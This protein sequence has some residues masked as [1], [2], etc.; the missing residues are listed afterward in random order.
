[1]TQ[2]LTDIIC[3]NCNI[4][5]KCLEITQANPERIDV[6]F[7]YGGGLPVDPV[8]RER[9]RKAIDQIEVTNKKAF[10]KQLR[11]AVCASVFAKI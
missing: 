1:M 8:V 2:F 7:N 6:T 4:P 3:E 5:T 9:A 11:S 10:S